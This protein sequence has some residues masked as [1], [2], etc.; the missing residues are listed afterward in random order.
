[1]LLE[2]LAYIIVAVVVVWTVIPTLREH[3]FVEQ[4]EAL[5]K[6][7]AIW[8]ISSLPIFFGIAFS[9]SKDFDSRSIFSGLTGSPFSWSEQ[10]VYASTYLAPV[11]YAVAGAFK[12]LSS[13][14]V[15]AK[16][17]RF[18]RIF[19]RYWRVF[20][21]ALALLFLSI[22]IFSSIKANPI[23]FKETL[24]YEYMNGKSMLIYFISWVYWY[25]IVLIEN[26]DGGDYN[27]SVSRATIKVTD[28]ARA[29][30]RGRAS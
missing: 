18:K 11:I 7:V 2:W 27:T 13:D 25:C 20:F 26:T 30:L 15:S 16:K 17:R 3:S 8:A 23:G 29:R 14:E 9:L 22:G 6:C 12:V 28:A 10:L 19:S 4:R 5:G 1:M 24:F 21:P